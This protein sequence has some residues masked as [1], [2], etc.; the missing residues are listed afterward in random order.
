MVYLAPRLQR[1]RPVLLFDRHDAA[2]A[3]RAGLSHGS[4]F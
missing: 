4:P 1:R 2:C 3:D